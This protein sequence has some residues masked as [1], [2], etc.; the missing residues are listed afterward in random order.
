MGSTFNSDKC[1][2]KKSDKKK[3]IKKKHRNEKDIYNSNNKMRVKDI[4]EDL[5]KKRFKQSRNTKKTGVIPKYYNSIQSTYSS[6]SE[7]SDDDSCYSLTDKEGCN[8][9]DFSDPTFFVD[10]QNS[11]VDNRK[12]ERKLVNKVKDT[13]NFTTQFDAL[14]LDNPS[15]PS[16]SNAVNENCGTNSAIKRMETE[17]TLAFEGGYSNFG[18]GDDNT[19]GVYQSDKLTHNNM[20]PFFSSNGSYGSNSLNKNK[21]VMHQRKMEMFT[22]NLNDPS[23]RPKTERKPLF[24]PLVGVTNIFGNAVQ[25]DD[26]EGRYIPGRERKNELPFQ[27]IKVTPGLGLGANERAKYGYHDMHRVLP[28]TTDEIRGPRGPK[29]SYKGVVISGK[30]GEKGRIMGKQVQRKADTFKEY[31]TERMVKSL[32]YIRGPTLYGE[33]NPKNLA[34][35]NRGT[36][37]QQWFGGA[38]S[39]N[40]H[41]PDQ[42]RGNFRRSGKQNFKQAEPRNIILVEGLGARPDSNS[43]IPDPT[44]RS[45]KNPYTGPAG[46]TNQQQGHAFNIVDGTPDPTRRD[47]HKI[48]NRV[49][50]VYGDNKSGYVI[51]Y[52][53]NMPQIT[54]RNTYEN[55]DRAGVNINGNKS[56]GHYAYNANDVPDM[57]MRN[58]H[59]ET[60]RMGANV[61]GHHKGHHMYDKNN[62]PDMNMRNV[63]SETDR[64]GAS[65]N[66]HHK[67]HHMYDKNNVP[68]MNMRNVHSETD[69]MGTN[70]NGHHKGHHTYN[71]CDVPDMNMRN[72]HN[73]SRNQGGASHRV[74]KPIAFN[75]EDNTPDVNMR[76][77]HNS[78]RNHG[79]ASH[80]V[81]KPIAFNYEDNTP[82]VNMRNIHNSSRNQGG[83]SHR[84]DK[85]IA[86]NYVDN[87]P[88]V[89][90]REIHKS[91]RSKGGATNSVN[92]PIAF[93]YVDNIPDVTMR[94]I[95]GETK[96]IAPAHAHEQG[97][98]RSRRDAYNMSVNTAKEHIAQG[99]MPTYSNYSKGPTMDMTQVELKKPIQVDRE[100]VP[101][102]IPCNGKMIPQQSY[103]GN[104]TYYVNDR[105]LS[106][107]EENLKHN[108]FVNNLVHKAVVK[109]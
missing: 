95:H 69:R 2:N 60:D 14:Q 3:R 94:E 37:D 74:D 45:Q 7:Y 58:V 67:G 100:L 109:T 34:T 55:A 64:M 77:I 78:S 68:D 62:V 13:D 90:M 51:N 82:D 11:I 83:A 30:R 81:D 63:H 73:S 28:K 19:Y 106:H 18:E 102:Y 89:T 54:N 108:V 25:T 80:R 6:D 49:G 38:N 75:Y 53:D 10:K 99:R 66:G 72:I 9:V 59:S 22:G 84:V 24:S 27:Q 56:G 5:S 97:M 8:S 61:N 43:Y 17:R 21:S 48:M 88:D 36:K 79:G 98:Q 29:I 31:G 87:I 96:S 41:T 12:Y 76:N 65:V 103:N 35:Q 32:G 104:S 15:I 39:N 4:S 1:D 47:I 42:L 107:I 105:I 57:N 71:Q 93:N 26:F 91:S 40:Q 85:P 33:F 44:Q 52:S 101:N 23:Y 46:T 92:K 86:F 50:G 70:V 16:S 20:V